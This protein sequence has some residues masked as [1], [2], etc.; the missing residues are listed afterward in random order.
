MRSILVNENG[1]LRAQRAD[2]RVTNEVGSAYPDEFPAIYELVR[3]PG[4]CLME[5]GVLHLPCFLPARGVSKRFNP[6]H[7]PV[8]FAGAVT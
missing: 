3:S 5:L 8:F 7:E 1:R 4:L 6:G 2:M